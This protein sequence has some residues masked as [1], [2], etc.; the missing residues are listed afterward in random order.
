MQNISLISYGYFDKALLDRIAENISQEFQ[1]QVELREGHL[2]LS[3]YYDPGRRQY[4]GTRLL[5]VVDKLPLES[6]YK[7]L[8]LFNVDLFIP[9]LTY[10]FGQAYLGGKSGIVSSYRLRN[11]LYGLKQDDKLLAGRIIKVCLHELGHM[12]GL[13]HCSQ[14]QCIMRSSTYVED[15]DLK[16]RYFCGECN[17]LLKKAPGVYG[18]GHP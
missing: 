17:E 18:D 15:I 6:S 10:I 7:T 5:E 1:S 11:E 9:I 2:D 14:P 13:V 12:H 3:L 16:E 8:A 4:N